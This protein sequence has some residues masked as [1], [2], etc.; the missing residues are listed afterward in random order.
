MFCNGLSGKPWDKQA[1]TL[2]YLTEVE[3]LAQ[4]DKPESGWKCPFC[5]LPAEWNDENYEEMIQ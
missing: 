3:Y 5:G 2:V 1:H 4:L